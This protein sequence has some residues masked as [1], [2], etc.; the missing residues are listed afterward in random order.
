MKYFTPLLFIIFLTSCTKPLKFESCDLRTFDC[1]GHVKQTNI[2]YINENGDTLRTDTLRFTEAGDLDLKYVITQS[3]DTIHRIKRDDE[4]RITELNH[5]WG[6]E[7]NND[8][9]YTS[10]FTYDNDGRLKSEFRTHWSMDVKYMP[11]F[12][13]QGYITRSSSEWSYESTVSKDNTK[14]KYIN[15]DQQGNWT[16]RLATTKSSVIDYALEDTTPQ[17]TTRTINEYREITYWQ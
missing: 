11:S 10:Q 7:H 12:N 1:V 8:S 15:K 3:G 6:Y 14:Y 4:G 5:A 16:H 17:I 9:Y 2:T 13:R